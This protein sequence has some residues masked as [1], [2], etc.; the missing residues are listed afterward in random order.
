[1][2]LMIGYNVP[3]GFVPSEA[4]PEQESLLLP[5]GLHLLGNHWEDNKVPTLCSVESVWRFVSGS[6]CMF[7]AHLCSYSVYIYIYH[8]LQP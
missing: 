3:V 4:R 5:V 6:T 1:M 2:C 7:K 8:V